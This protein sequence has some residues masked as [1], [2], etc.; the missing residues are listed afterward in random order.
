MRMGYSI[1]CFLSLSVLSILSACEN[2]QSGSGANDSLQ[3]ATAQQ[4]GVNESNALRVSVPFNLK[5]DPLVSTGDSDGL[6]PLC[7]QA[8]V[9][10]NKLE[11]VYILGKLELLEKIRKMKGNLATSQTVTTRSPLSVT[12]TFNG[13]SVGLNTDRKSTTTGSGGSST[14][15]G[16]SAGGGVGGVTVQA[17][18]STVIDE[19]LYSGTMEFNAGI[20]LTK[21][22]GNTVVINQIPADETH[23]VEEATN[24]WYRTPIFCNI[25]KQCKGLGLYE[26]N[27]KSAGYCGGGSFSFSSGPG[28][29]GNPGNPGGPGRPGGPGGRP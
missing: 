1:F 20:S 26:E 24:A 7:I 12:M 27:H 2:G 28:S 22:L 8:L 11:E 16:G 29:P 17:P 5:S 21:P 6:E 9:Y 10:Q 15:G 4:A 23:M 19:G 3:A 14:V 13:R 18:S 25:M